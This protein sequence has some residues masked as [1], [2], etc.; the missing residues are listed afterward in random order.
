MLVSRPSARMISHD[1]PG[2]HSIGVVL[3]PAVTLHIL[4]ASCFAFTG[5]RRFVLQRQS[6]S[7]RTQMRPPKLGNIRNAAGFSEVG[8]FGLASLLPPRQ[9]SPSCEKLRFNILF[10]DVPGKSR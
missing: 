3:L 4:K 1:F 5:G 2:V 8:A 7:Q 6:R 10:L 9:Q